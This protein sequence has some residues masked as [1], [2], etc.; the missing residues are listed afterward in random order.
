[1][2]MNYL[3]DKKYD[4]T[5]TINFIGTEE[6]HPG[7]TLKLVMPECF[8]NVQSLDGYTHT[9]S[10][11][12]SEV[13]LKVF[14]RYKYSTDKDW[15]ETLPISDLSLI[16]LCSRKCLLIELIYFRVDEGGPNEDIVIT[17]TNPSIN[18]TYSLTKGDA[19]IILTPD[20]TYQILEVGDF[21]KIFSISDFQVISTPRNGY[22]IKY[23]FSQDG[24]MS[25]TD[26]EPLTRENIS[27][28][29]W[30]S[31]RFVE[32]QYLFELNPGAGNIKI[33]E[34]LLYGDFQNVSANSLKLNFFGLKEN[35]VSLAFPT[36]NIGEQTSGINENQNA[37]DS[38][39]PD[40]TTT[41][42]VKEASEYQLRMNWLTYGLNC[43]S[44]PATVG[45]KSIID[46]ITAQNEANSSGFWNPYEF[47]KIT[48]W[49]DMLANQIAQMLGMQVEYHLTDPDGNGIDK[50]IH[51]HQLYNITDYKMIKVLVPENQFPDNQ[52]VINQFNLDLFDTFKVHILKTEFKKAFGV[53]KRPSQEDILYFCQVNRMYIVKHAQIH[54]DVLNS[55][56]YYNVVLEKYEKRA[57]ILNR[58]EES[59]NRIEELTR[60][61]TIDELFGFEEE[62]DMKKIANKQQL[63]PKSFDYIRSV[64]NARTLIV[65]ESVYNG[66]IKVVESYYNMSNVGQDEY[67]VQY[68]KADN[69]V[70]VS[71]NRSFIFWF[72]L[73]NDYQEGKGINKKVIAGYDVSSNEYVLLN[74]MADDG[75]G[76]KVW[77]QSNKIYYM[78]NEVIHILETNLLTNVWYAIVINMDQRQRTCEIRLVRRNAAINVVLYQ[79]DTYER[80][81]LDFV[82]DAD[83]IEYEVNVNGFKRVDN[84]EITSPEVNPTFIEVGYYSKS[85]VELS[86]FNHNV[87][88]KINGSKMKLSN[89]RVFNDLIRKEHQNIVLNE[90]I[91]KD[92]QHL[93]LAD[94]ATK[95][96]F[97]TNYPN[98]NWR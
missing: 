5:F 78:I 57:N 28:V 32:L 18:G 33:Y 14:F 1:M 80:L 53:T 42:L 19:F 39:T 59:K 55:G 3:L 68:T 52:I 74:N 31:T 85:D 8:K 47:G 34:V 17:L 40:S 38:K 51:E 37:F 35:C 25:W 66:A 77:I 86:E 69:E 45:G 79:P 6:F 49:Q 91:V 84:I 30:D 16:E 54:K 64:I 24:K 70:K 67:A 82:E 46:E 87:D 71:D 62:N 4:E 9:T 12:T 56:I 50:V 81:D 13:Y 22:T 29:H 21:L 89:I 72:N 36:A 60:N 63:K 61:T 93:I 95:K 7:N 43:Y 90:L 98:K 75:T 83:D 58:I 11:E 88:F 48:E 27:T 15:S 92:A 94:N 20:D 2:A 10:G 65:N 44:N 23:R 73:P 41:S 96:I 97:T 26:W 76:Y